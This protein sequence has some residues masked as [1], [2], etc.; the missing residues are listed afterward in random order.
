MTRKYRCTYKPYAL[1]LKNANNLLSKKSQLPFLQRTTISIY[2]SL[3]SIYVSV[4]TCFSIAFVKFV[5]SPIVTLN[6]CCFIISS[7]CFLNF[8]L[9]SSKNLKQNKNNYFY[10]NTL[11]Q[12]KNRRMSPSEMKYPPLTAYA[13]RGINPEW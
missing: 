13:N 11:K 6:T 2:K 4:S 5:I 8:W 10:C 1:K 3:W 12:N 7:V 9:I